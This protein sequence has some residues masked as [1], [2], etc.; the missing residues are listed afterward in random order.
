MA[1]PVVAQRLSG[2]AEGRVEAYFAKQNDRDPAAIGWGRV[3][4][5][6][7]APLGPLRL[8]LTL[9]AEEATSKDV[10]RLEWDPADRELRRS[11]LS[12]REAWVRAPIASGLD[13]TLGRQTLGWGK[14]DGYSP[15]DAFLPRDLGNPSADEKLPV[16][17]VRAQGTTG[18]LR[19]DAF[20]AVTT[21]PWR[22]P[23][24]EGRNAPLPVPNAFLVDGEQ[25]PP[26]DGF[27]AVRLL[28]SF[29]DWDVGLWG[30]AGVRP[31]PLLVFRL[32]RVTPVSDGFEIPVDRRFA[33][34]QGLGGEV[35]RV[36]GGFVVRAELAALF[37][38]DPELGD[39]ILWTLGAERAFGDGTLL[40]TFAANAR[41]VRV[42]KA[43]LL[44]RA[45]L[46]G[47]IAAWTRTEDWGSWRLVWSQALEHGDGLA[48]AEAGWNLT[49]VWRLTPGLELLYGSSSGPF[50]ARK[51][52]SRATLDVRRSW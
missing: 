17:G 43:L 50:G 5:T 32:D 25:R 49:D 51:K 37:S 31:A 4:L 42:P 7:E 16:W 27:G 2:H 1:E 33:R 39:A 21:T 18:V 10:G 35:S 29:G 36:V 40:V 45:F 8:S 23:I 38:S 19:A 48:R 20:W 44:D 28:A 47:L 26:R 24:L 46:P 13:V 52:G 6:G 22:L 3:L 15:A 11:P 30:R 9:R 34:E 12:I 41:P 14:T